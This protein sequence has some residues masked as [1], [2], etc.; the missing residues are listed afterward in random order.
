MKTIQNYPS[1][2][3]KVDVVV[4]LFPLKILHVNKSVQ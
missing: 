3:T 2:K 4:I 1:D